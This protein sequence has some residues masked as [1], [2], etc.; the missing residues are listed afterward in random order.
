M[1][2]VTINTIAEACDEILLAYLAADMVLQGLISAARLA[3]EALALAEQTGIDWIID[4]ARAVAEAAVAAVEIAANIASSLAQAYIDCLQ[5]QIDSGSCD[6][7][8]C[9]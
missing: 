6:S 8:S 2:F 1:V 5:D 4:A 9:G 3:I 7:G